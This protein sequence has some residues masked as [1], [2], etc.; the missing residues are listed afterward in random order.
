MTA[1][2]HA[3]TKHEL[4]SCPGVIQACIVF[5]KDGHYQTQMADVCAA[6]SKTGPLSCVPMW[7][8]C[9]RASEQDAQ[10]FRNVWL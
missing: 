7:M 1:Y 6:V 2:T 3:E 5:S 4:T 10:D 9:I 8:R